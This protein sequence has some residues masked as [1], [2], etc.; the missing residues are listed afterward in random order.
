MGHISFWSVLTTYAVGKI[1][2]GCLLRSLVDTVEL[3]ASII[4]VMK[5]TSDLITQYKYLLTLLVYFITIT[6]TMKPVLTSAIFPF[7]FCEV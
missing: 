4:R 5:R 2:D 3:T 7:V 6:S 1:K